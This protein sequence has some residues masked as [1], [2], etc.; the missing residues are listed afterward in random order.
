MPLAVMF[1]PKSMNG[2]QYDDIIVRLA[3]VGEGA[4]HG[5]LYHACYGSGDALHVF[6][7][8]DSQAS[9]EHFGQ[10][11]MPILAEVGID[12]GE[13]QINPTHSLIPG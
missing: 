3:E 12:P 7:I 10:K 9:F 2:D 11:L 4:P 6:D 13:P 5:R 8:W 1:S